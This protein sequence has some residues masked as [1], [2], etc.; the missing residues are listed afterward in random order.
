MFILVSHKET[1]LTSSSL[2]LHFEEVLIIFQVLIM[3]KY[4]VTQE[5]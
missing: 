3:F 5:F 1:L 2:G 4:S